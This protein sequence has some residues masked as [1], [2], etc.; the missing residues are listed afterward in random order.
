MKTTMKG[1]ATR[2]F[3]MGRASVGPGRKGFEADDGRNE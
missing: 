1:R 3:Q 2:R